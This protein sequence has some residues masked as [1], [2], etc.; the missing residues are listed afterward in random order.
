MKSKPITTNPELLSK[1][2]ACKEIWNNMTSDEKEEV[3]RKQRESWSRQD[4]D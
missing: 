3:L 1:L 2:Q 4:M